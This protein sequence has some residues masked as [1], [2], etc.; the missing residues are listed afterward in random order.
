M[1]ST[2]PK[3]AL[4]ATVSTGA[5]PDSSAMRALS[6]RAHSTKAAGVMPTSRPKARAKFRSLMCARS[7]SAGTERSAS[8]LSAIQACRSRSGRRSACCAWS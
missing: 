2:V 8:T 4:T 1:V 7:A 3:P 6:T 5:S